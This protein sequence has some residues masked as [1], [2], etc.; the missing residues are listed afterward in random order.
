M[1]TTVELINQNI[2]KSNT[3]LKKFKLLYQNNYEVKSL[4]A[5]NVT[6]QLIQHLKTAYNFEQSDFKNLI[7][8][9]K[10]NNETIKNLGGKDIAN[11]ICQ[12]L[13]NYLY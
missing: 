2:E 3:I 7:K 10:T 5:Q 8:D 6:I 4:K 13:E 9:Y 12:C 1:Q 11:Y